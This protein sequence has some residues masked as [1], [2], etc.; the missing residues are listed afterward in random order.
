MSERGSTL[1]FD[2]GGT[3]V[4]A[5]RIDVASGEVQTFLRVPLPPDAGRSELVTRIIG[6][7]ADAAEGVVDRIGVAVPGP[8]DYANGVSCSPTSSSTCTAST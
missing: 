1:A 5:G 4:S 3:H 2:L 6:V 7:G 8:F